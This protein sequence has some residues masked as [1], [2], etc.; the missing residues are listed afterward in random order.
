MGRWK[1][2]KQ[3]YKS[4]SKRNMQNNNNGSFSPIDLDRL[5]MYL[6]TYRKGCER[7]CFLDEAD[8]SEDD[9]TVVT[10]PACAQMIDADD[11]ADGSE[12]IANIA[13][14]ALNENIFAKPFLALP[15]SMTAKQRK[16]I[17]KICV[18]GKIKLLL[19]CLLARFNE[20][21]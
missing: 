20:L 7:L 16:A 4:S 9:E 5:K 8:V 10:K 3:F 18:D 11:D 6:V 17:H 2:K 13:F 14:P 21:N 15:N 12:L 1:R 19:A